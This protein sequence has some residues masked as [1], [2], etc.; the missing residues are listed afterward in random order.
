MNEWD[1][2]LV[3]LFS[4]IFPE[5]PETKLWQKGEKQSQ[6]SQGLKPV[7]QTQMIPASLCADPSSLP[8]H[9][10]KIPN[11]HICA[12][13]SASLSIQWQVR[14]KAEPERKSNSASV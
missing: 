2:R 4:E 12:F 5:W 3:S 13:P 14:R 1:S 9:Y 8:S 7:L 11:Y 6:A 10:G